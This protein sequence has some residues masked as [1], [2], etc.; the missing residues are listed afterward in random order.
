[1]NNEKTKTQ[2]DSKP[3]TKQDKKKKPILTEQELKVKKAKRTRVAA[4]SFVLLLGLGILGN[5]YFENNKL[6]ESIQPLIN[7]TERVKNLGEAEYVDAPAEAATKENE[8]F[9]T[10]RV[11][12]Q[13]TRDE[14]VEKLQ[15]VLDKTDESE[16]A[17]KKAA[18]DM[19]QLTQ[20]IENENKIETLVTAKGVNN[21]LAVVS[22]DGKKVDVIVDAEE[23]GDTL[24]MQIKEIAISQLNCSFEDVSIIQS[25]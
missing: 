20:N 10:A 9:A 4:A 8:Y 22:T 7:A 21:C 14:A 11:E 1:M 25:K 15:S 2:P 12:R 18:D 17:R 19:A 23:L 5:W 24:I 16:Q 13:N 3:E 6:S